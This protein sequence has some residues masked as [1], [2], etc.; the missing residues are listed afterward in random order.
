MGLLTVGHPLSWEDS[1][2]YSQYVREHG[3]LQFLNVWN[4]IKDIKDD[5]LRW[6]DEIECGYDF[7]C[8]LF[9][10]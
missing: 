9:F 2:K 1:K 5:K 4:R 7:F 3:I 10:R 6:G 8:Y